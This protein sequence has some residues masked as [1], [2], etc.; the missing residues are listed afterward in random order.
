MA[1]VKITGHAS[2]TGILTVTAPNTSTDRTIT[3]PDATGT[4]LNSDGSAA[5]LT[6][7]PAANITGTLPAISGASLTSLPIQNRPNSNP[8]IINGDMSVSQRGTANTDESASGFYRVDRMNV[9][10]SNIGEFRLSQESLSS[11]A[12][13]NAGFKKAFRIDCAV[14]DASPASGDIGNMTYKLEGNTVQAFKKGTSNAETATL[15]FWVKSNKTGTAQ[16]TLIDGDNSRQVGATYTIS[17]AD[18][19]EHKVLN[20]AAD[21]TGALDNDNNKS[22]EIEF[23]LDA[24]SDFTSGAV[25]SAWEASANTDRSVNDLA[26]QDNTANDWAITG[27]QLEVG[28]Y[29]SATLPPFQFESYG[30]NLARCQRYYQQLVN[31][32]TGGLPG[33]SPYSAGSQVFCPYSFLT[34]MRAAPT[35]VT[36]NNSGDFRARHGDLVTFATYDGFNGVSPR[37]CTF[38]TDDVSGSVVGDFYWMEPNQSTALL[39]L[40]SEL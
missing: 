36:S 14:A 31:G 20:Y 1:K 5:S 6:A 26:L 18:T 33:G 35:L 28:T 3:L 21:T 40:S 29:T 13:F 15:A 9:G 39:A 12:A 11:G 2:G 24:G 4:L 19:W 25:P 34:E 27:L 30:D 37:N 38:A 10:M 23:A 16:V 7:I 32:T 22:L 8:I 17:S